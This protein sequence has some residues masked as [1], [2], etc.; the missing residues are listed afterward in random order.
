MPSC[1]RTSQ[2]VCGAIRSVVILSPNGH[3]C[4]SLRRDCPRTDQLNILLRHLKR[5]KV[6]RNFFSEPFV[7]SRVLPGT[8]DAL[9]QTSSWSSP[10]C[11]PPCHGGDRGFKSHR[12]RSG[13][14]PEEPNF[15]N[16]IPSS[17]GFFEFGSWNL[18]S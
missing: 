12:G 7:G 13:V 10:E 9:Q 17:L 8:A 3:V 14:G 5:Q 6:H 15:K 1:L 11:S 4:R 2:S 16:Q 18:L